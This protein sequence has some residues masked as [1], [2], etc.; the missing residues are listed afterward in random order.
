MYI[1]FT[2]SIPICDLLTSYTVYDRESQ[3]WC[4]PIDWHKFYDVKSMKLFFQQQ[5]V[6][7]YL[8]CTEDIQDL[9]LTP[10]EQATLMCYMIATVGECS[11]FVFVS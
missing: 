1:F 2:A 8:K 4:D 3:I 5:D 7:L 11:D 10:E 9:D 6:D